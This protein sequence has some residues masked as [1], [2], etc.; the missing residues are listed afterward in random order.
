MLLY[1]LD[2]QLQAWGLKA[3]PA[4]LLLSV[5]GLQI[6]S[7]NGKPLGSWSSCMLCGVRTETCCLNSTLHTVCTA[8]LKE[9]QYENLLVPGDLHVRVL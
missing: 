5:R 3:M 2:P 7:R 6:D 8:R 9:E 1:Y 4:K